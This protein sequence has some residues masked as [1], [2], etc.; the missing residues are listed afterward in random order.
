[1]IRRTSRMNVQGYSEGVEQGKVSQ[2]EQQ[3]RD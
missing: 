3:H 1:M 2:D